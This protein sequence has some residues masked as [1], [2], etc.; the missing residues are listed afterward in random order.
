MKETNA[1]VETT[2]RIPG[3][4]HHPQDLIARIPAGYRL[5]ARALVLPNGT[6]V[7]FTPLAPD[8]MFA[9]VFQLA[10]RRSATEEEIKRVNHYTVNIA[11]TGP[12]GSLAAALTMM[13]AGA[14]IVRAGGAGVFIDNSAMAHG[15]DDW[16]EMTEDGSIDAVSFSFVNITR[17][18]REVSTM[19]MRVLGKPDIVMELSDVDDDCKIIIDVIRYICR[20]DTPV[21]NGRK[22]MGLAGPGFRVQS[23]RADG[24]KCSSPMHN[25]FG[26]VKLTPIQDTTHHN[27]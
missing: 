4:W 20:E 23:A 2:L 16:V 3:T 21:R 11:L 7:E 15:G 13:H 25:P 27:N 24:L 10:C 12:G 18:N 5:T 14:A 8:E 22:R 17:G 26:R 1:V 6:E 19:G 9:K